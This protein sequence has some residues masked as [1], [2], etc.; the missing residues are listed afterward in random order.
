MQQDYSAKE[1]ERKKLAPLHSLVGMCA[2]GQMAHA[3]WQGFRP[4]LM[5]LVRPELG[6]R[7]DGWRQSFNQQRPYTVREEMLSLWQST[8]RN[9]KEIA[10]LRLAVD[11]FK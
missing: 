10:L 8:K 5:I 2:D 3:S 4:S 9:E 6:L 11:C 7:P 1:A